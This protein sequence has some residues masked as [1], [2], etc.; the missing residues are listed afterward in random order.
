MMKRLLGGL[1]LILLWSTVS[2]QRVDLASDSRLQ[3]KLTVQQPLIPLG[4]LL[5]LIQQQTET[6][7][8]A[9]RA[10]ADDKV[11]LLVY[12][13]P[14]YE[15]LTR[16]AETLRYE[17]DFSVDGK[18]YRLFQ[19]AGERAREEALRRAYDQARLEQAQKPLREIL[20]LVRRYRYE[21]LR[22]LP[23]SEQERLSPE[24]RFFI[25]NASPATVAL[26]QLAG[27]LTE[28]AWRQLFTGETIVFA[29]RPQPGAQ[30]LPE[31]AQRVILQEIVVDS[32]L[33]Q[34][35]EAQL[36]LNPRTLQLE[37]A[38][39]QRR[40]GANLA[41][42]TM[43][44]AAFWADQ[45]GL[46]VNLEN[47][48]QNRVWR[49]WATAPDALRQLTP[50]E[51]ALPAPQPL[52][53]SIRNSP[54]VA[55]IRFARE[56]KLDLYADAYRIR[57][58][59]RRNAERTPRWDIQSLQQAVFWL[60]VDGDALM[61]RHRDYFLLRPSEIP[62]RALTGLEAKIR[63]REAISLDEWA[64][65]GESLTPMQIARADE[66]ISVG[67]QPIAHE[68]LLPLGMVVDILPALRFWN[69]LSPQQRRA[70]QDGN[71]I[72]YQQM[73]ARQ[74]ERFEQA[75]LYSPPNRSRETGERG[76]VLT[77]AS[78]QVI[79]LSE[80]SLRTMS[81]RAG[82]ISPQSPHFRLSRQIISQGK[83]Y[84]IDGDSVALTPPDSSSDLH[85]L[86][87]IF[88]SE[89]AERVYLL[90]QP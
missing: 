26:L 50:R 12:D 31:W 67:G 85:G 83:R 59:T 77:D 88:I 32:G 6:P 33:P 2:A 42:E 73:N 69:T 27:Q 40:R 82:N 16:L 21:Q 30:P 36:M 37:Y 25:Q 54:L 66:A 81:V 75:V 45:S 86:R 28:A 8:F 22:N 71:P 62:E 38:L 76:I 46:S 10:L 35:I 79:S 64:Q 58:A 57:L 7:L 52:P 70:A 48:I 53:E 90:V 11:C 60:R 14:A 17:W 44:R 63:K 34:E 4:E 3:A 13:K 20:N 23:P 65:L 29:S 74:R 49:E 87:L 19:P 5:R 51:R 1:G 80:N 89:N 41:S 43:I 47:H 61:A 24:A 55:L 15:I 68:T 56:H 72:P 78:Q 9:D 84:T 18:G 39:V